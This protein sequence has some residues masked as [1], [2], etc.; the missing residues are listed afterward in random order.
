MKGA[1]ILVITNGDSAA[2]AIRN[3]RLE[4]E[5]ILPWRDVLH[6]GP[7]P[8]DVSV[9]ILREI[10]AQHL[11]HSGYG[12][13]DEIA[14]QFNDRDRLIESCD[15]FDEIVLWFEHDLYDQLQLIQVMARLEG[16]SADHAS[17]AC[18][19][20]FVAQ[21]SSAQLE[22]QF[23]HRRPVTPQAYAE[24]VH[25]WSC[26]T[27]P[28]PTAMVEFARAP[29]SRA[30]PH[31]AP[32]FRRLIAEFPD[33]DTGLSSTEEFILRQLDKHGALSGKELFRKH[34]LVEQAEFMGDWSFFRILIDL[35]APPNPLVE[36][37]EDVTFQL[38]GLGVEDCADRS[39]RILATGRKA[40]HGEIN[41]IGLRGIDRWIGGVH[42]VTNA[43][44]MR[45]TV[46]SRVDS[47]AYSVLGPMNLKDSAGRSSNL[48]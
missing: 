36:P 2:G 22:R 17:L 39:F 41:A 32:A 42:L 12:E 48:R 21:Q 43:V 23:D 27:S 11:A 15:K 29:A 34:T 18:D 38:G 28:D 26:F 13:M 24:A 4:V 33:R 19:D 45:K 9:S 10:R 16:L 5:H 30:L 14:A 46:D 35:A 47:P 7:V 25:A 37:T 3:T 6:E 44:W 20:S 8:G 31:V 1:S 40:V